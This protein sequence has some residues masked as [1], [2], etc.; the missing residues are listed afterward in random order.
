MENFEVL[1]SLN[2]AKAGKNT[3]LRLGDIDGDGRMELIFSRCNKVSDE[4]F[5]APKAVSITVFNLDGE[6]L[7]QIGDAEAESGN[8]KAD[9]P[10]QI[11]DIDKDGKNEV[12]AVMEDQLYI[13]DG[14]TSEIKK[15]VQLPSKDIGGSLVICDLEGSG[16][17]QNIILKNKLSH[18]WAFDV[19]LNVIWD[20]EGNVGLCPVCYDINGDGKDEIIAGYN[21]L[22][23]RGELLW[24]IDMPKHAKTICVEKLYKNDVPII[25]ISGPVTRAYLPDGEMLWELPEG[26]ENIAVSNFR[27]NAKDKDILLMPALS[28]FDNHAAFL[29]EKN[30][31]IYNPVLV[32]NFDDTK[33]VYIA[34]R[35][36]EDICTT[37]YDGY[38]R[39]A[40]T[41]DSIGSIACCDLLGSGMSQVIVYN[42]DTASIYSSSKINFE[43]PSRPYQMQ[44]QKQYYNVSVHNTLPTS[45]NSFGYL[46][47][48]FA[49]Q[50]ILKWAET[51]A[52]LNMHNS[53]A[54]VLRSEFVLL[55]A[56]MLNLKE[57]IAE[58]FADVPK[59]ATYAEAVGTF[60]T[61]GIIES[62]DNFFQP[63]DAITVSA[64]NDILEKLSMNIFFNF[65][66]KYE[67]SKQD[68]ARFILSLS[69]QDGQ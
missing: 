42:D 6:L 60:K 26:T 48:D 7:W 12:I 11:Y 50:N 22:S 23:G 58:N 63:D 35:K 54:K 56:T 5:F 68:M 62:E 64:A 32:W 2:I 59:S 17:A 33:K 41:L 31:T 65:D 61:L 16:Y 25:I 4:R 9:I 39:T 3:T 43:E 57:E 51:Y 20:F 21:V 67:L 27:D 55:L 14:K 30:E 28:L 8:T 34:G 19:N 66:E 36:T 1:K 13:F 44:Q 15:Q 18:L 29:Y 45:Q 24:K 10:V 49:A 53:Y 46:A 52:S 47:D 69:S 37:L 38:M 40:Y